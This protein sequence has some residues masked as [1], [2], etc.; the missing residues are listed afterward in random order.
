[1]GLLYDAPPV[2]IL[3]VM[4]GSEAGAALYEVSL[5]V[6]IALLNWAGLDWRDCL[7]SYFNIS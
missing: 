1:M 6:V 5:W 2:N 7:A 3:S 4:V